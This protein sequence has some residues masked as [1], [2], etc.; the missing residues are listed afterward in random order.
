MVIWK[1]GKS[2]DSQVDAWLHAF[3]YVA[4]EAIIEFSEPQSP[5]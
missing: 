1:L 4:L 3:N 5:Y 2:M